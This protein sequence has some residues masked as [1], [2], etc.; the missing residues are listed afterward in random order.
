MSEF[1]SPLYSYQLLV[2]VRTGARYSLGFTLNVPSWMD[3][4]PNARPIVLLL[5]PC[6][7]LE[8]VWGNDH[9]SPLQ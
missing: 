3:S 8:A 1:Y 7:P 5:A 4:G 9:P 6:S 2:P